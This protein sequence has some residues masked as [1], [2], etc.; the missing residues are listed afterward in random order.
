MKQQRALLAIV[1]A[2]SI[3]CGCGQKGPLFLPGERDAQ[4]EIPELDRETIEEM[5]EGGEDEARRPSR[6][7]PE[8]RQDEA[9]PYTD[10]AAP[11]EEPFDH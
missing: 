5:L 4:S 8:Q 10:P 6:T 7:R 2:G 1:L 11:P 9:E 3:A